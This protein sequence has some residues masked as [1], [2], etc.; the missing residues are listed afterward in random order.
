MYSTKKYRWLMLLIVAASWLAGSLAQADVV[1]DWNITAGDI[2]VAA[3]LPP[4]PTYRIMA[5]VQ[6]A[7]YEAVNAI[8]KRYPSERV[9]LDAAP[10]ASV[11]A[12]VA[13]A[14]RATLLQLVPHSRP[15][16]TA[17]IRRRCP[18]F[19][20]ARRRPPGLRSGKRRRQR[21]WRGAPRT[22]PP[23]QRR[24]DRTPR[25]GST[26]RQSSRW[27]RNGHSARRG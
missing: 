16:S 23:R 17:P 19:P 8:T 18:A 14:N 24:T 13:A 2:A 9:K 12:A 22:A 7:V 26:C 20:L 10:G 11:D 1:T 25:Q 27:S 5:I 15:R 21:S 4:P 6:S 3:K